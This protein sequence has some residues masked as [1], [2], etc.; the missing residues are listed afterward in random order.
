M[1]EEIL[2]MKIFAR[3]LTA[4]LAAAALFS[5]GCGTT[6][7]D[8]QPQ[9]ELTEEEQIA[10]EIDALSSSQALVW[11]KVLLTL[12]KYRDVNK[13]LADG[14]I[15][16]SGCE[17]APGLGGMGIHYLNPA[18]AAD[19]VND[20]YKPELL[21]YAPNSTGGLDLLGPEYFQAEA[22]QARP[23]VVGQPFDGPMPG[24]NPQMPTH[25][26]LHVWLFKY[27]PAG[28]FAPFNSRVKCP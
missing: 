16:V 6:D 8:T 3:R 11:G 2:R 21:L 5:V 7:E 28:L 24:H 22:G 23:A 17:A 18:L 15:P 12:A 26:D 4:T 19:L 27:N 25:Y 14:Y 1:E 10:A 9:V 13:A 20:P